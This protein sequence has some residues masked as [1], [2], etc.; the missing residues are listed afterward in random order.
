MFN[1]RDHI[2]VHKE[3]LNKYFKIEVVSYILSDHDAIQL[4]IHSKR[5]Y[6]NTYTFEGY[7][8]YWRNQEGNLIVPRTK[9]KWKY[10]L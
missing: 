5:N 2:L 10:N 6:T 8:G 9:W 7:M 4:D 1:N 3:I